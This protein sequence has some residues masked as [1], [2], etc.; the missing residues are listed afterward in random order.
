MASGPG[1]SFFDWSVL[2][3]LIGVIATGIL[4]EILRLVQFAPALYVVYFVHLVLIFVLFI[5]APYSKFAHFAYRTVAVA[6]S[7]PWKPKRP[8]SSEDQ[9]KLIELYY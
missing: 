9:K 6:L 4:S 2:G 7:E 8:M 1:A 5:Y 3:T